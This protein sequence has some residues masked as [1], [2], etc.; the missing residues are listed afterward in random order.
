VFDDTDAV[1]SI[2]LRSNNASSSSSVNTIN[3]EIKKWEVFLKAYRGHGSNTL[4]CSVVSIWWMWHVASGGCGYCQIGQAGDWMVSCRVNNE[5][6]EFYLI[7]RD[8]FQQELCFWPLALANFQNCKASLL[9][10][11]HRFREHCRTD[12][13]ACILGSQGALPFLEKS[14]DFFDRII[15]I[16]LEDMWFIWYV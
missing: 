9:N 7:I 8:L 13:K 2:S 4:Q 3:R 11:L 1:D 10:W 14:M 6:K 5:C 15:E 16:F 12:L